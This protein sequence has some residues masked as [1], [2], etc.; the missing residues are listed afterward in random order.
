MPDSSLRLF[1]AWKRQIATLRII[2]LWLVFGGVM[3]TFFL[4]HDFGPAALQLRNSKTGSNAW[5]L[6]AASSGVMVMVAGSLLWYLVKR[7]L[8]NGSPSVAFPDLQLATEKALAEVNERLKLCQKKTVEVHVRNRISGSPASIRQERRKLVVIFRPDFAVLVG[9]K[10]GIA[11]AFL[12]HELTHP[13][14]WDT[15][16]GHFWFQTQRLLAIIVTAFAFLAM[17]DL[18]RQAGFEALRHDYSAAWQTLR[19]VAVEGLAVLSC[20]FVTLWFFTVTRWAEFCADLSAAIAG[21]VDDIV[22]LLGSAIGT[23]NSLWRRFWQLSR[24]SN[25]SRLK[26]LQKYRAKL[27]SIQSDREGYNAP[28]WAGL[29]TQ[30]GFKDYVFALFFR[31]IPF[32]FCFMAIVMLLIALELWIG[33]LGKVLTPM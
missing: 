5:I 33:D 20:V 13:F 10:P 27:T 19:Y 17:L 3:A 25:I 23:K 9:Q 4:I 21:Y 32:F 1:S 29:S 6:G 30:P 24:P 11:R 14:Q 18:A 12:A 26:R 22:D 31:V 8:R 16:F 7:Y 28:F 2:N 15:R